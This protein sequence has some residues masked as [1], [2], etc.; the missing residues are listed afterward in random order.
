[1][2]TVP[3]FVAFIIFSAG[4]AWLIRTIIYPSRIS[5]AGSGIID[6]IVIGGGFNHKRKELGVRMVDTLQTRGDYVIVYYT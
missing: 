6:R 4:E 5:Q 1:M 3:C 2:F